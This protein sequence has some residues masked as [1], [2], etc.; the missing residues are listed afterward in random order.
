VA[1]I[2]YGLDKDED[3]DAIEYSETEVVN[4]TDEP[5][6]FRI[7]TTP[8]A[9]AR[10]YTLAPYGKPGDSI[11][12][13]TGYAQPY[14]GA[15]QHHLLEPIIHR[16]TK[17][18]VAPQTRNSDGQLVNTP[19]LPCVVRREVAAQFRDQWLNASR[20]AKQANVKRQ[21]LTIEVDPTA[22]SAPV[23]AAR[24]SAPP[25]LIGEEVGDEPIDPIAPPDPDEPMP[26]DIPT[27]ADEPPMLARPPQT[28]GGSNKGKG[29]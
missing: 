23:R 20:A 24:V 10:R 14:L 6:K 2:N 29:K 9:K 1:A 16:L 3:E 18:H 28:G 25:P 22:V 19:R 7:A 5:V 17:R 21:T 27:I 4:V 12:I 26:A 13:Q 11:N 15:G 8:G